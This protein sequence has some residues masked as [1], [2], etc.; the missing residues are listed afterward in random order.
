MQSRQFTLNDF[1]NDIRPREDLFF[2]EA[3][4]LIIIVELAVENT[5]ELNL[6]RCCKELVL[7]KIFPNDV[8][9]GFCIPLIRTAIEVDRLEF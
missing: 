6:Q 8:E 2:L 1:G 7:F 4:L 5:R 9:A 3:L